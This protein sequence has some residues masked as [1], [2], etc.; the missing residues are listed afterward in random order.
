MAITKSDIKDVLKEY[1]VIIEKT[2]GKA[3]KEYGVVTEIKLKIELNKTKRELQASIANVAFNSP[4][5]DQ[6]NKLERRVIR[7]E[8]T[9]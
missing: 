3:L 6:F 1:G 4:T 5:S 7:L 9:N 2:L 8:A